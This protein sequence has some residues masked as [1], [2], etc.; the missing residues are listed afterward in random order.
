MTDVHHYDRRGTDVNVT[1]LDVRV[2]G[3]EGR[4]EIVENKV[5]TT[6]RELLA[7]TELTKQVHSM[8]ERI[9]A[10]VSDVVHAVKWLSTTKK[11]LLVVMT[12]VAGACGAIV[13]A[14]SALKGLGIL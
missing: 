12:G 14:I 6:N 11:L 4:M 1:A 13:A 7:N 8:A 5:E 3:L 9:E 10:D 2:R